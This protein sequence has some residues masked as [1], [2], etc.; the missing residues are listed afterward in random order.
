MKFYIYRSKFQGSSLDFEAFLHLVKLK[1][2]VLNVE[3]KIAEWKGKLHTHFKKWQIDFWISLHY[4]V[5]F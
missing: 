2:N 1:R 4:V 3:Y 5:R